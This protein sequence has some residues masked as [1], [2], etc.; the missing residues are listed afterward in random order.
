M[1]MTALHHSLDAMIRPL[2][3]MKMGIVLPSKM[4][5]THSEYKTRFYLTNIAGA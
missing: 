1:H 3:K 5:L 4:I 2:H